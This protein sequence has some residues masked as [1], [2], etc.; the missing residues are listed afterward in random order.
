MSY[1]ANLFYGQCIKIR[2]LP[3]LLVVFGWYNLVMK[4]DRKQTLSKLKNMLDDIDSEQQN[5]AKC[6][7]VEELDAAL[8]DIVE[9]NTN[10]ARN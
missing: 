2:L 1:I 8:K 6:Y 4:N 3:C 5:G 7:S 9:Q 10:Q